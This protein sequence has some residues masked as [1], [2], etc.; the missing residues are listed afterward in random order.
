M[1]RGF[2]Y[3][4]RR[5]AGMRAALGLA[6]SV[7]YLADWSSEGTFTRASEA[8]VVDPR[9]GWGFVSTDPAT[10]MGAAVATAENEGSGQAFSGTTTITTGVADPFGG[11]DA[12]T[13]ADD[14]GSGFETANTPQSMSADVSDAMV[15]AFA[16]KADA[17]AGAWHRLILRQGTSARTTFE[18]DPRTGDWRVNGGSVTPARVAFYSSDG[19][20]YVI[21]SYTAGQ[22]TTS[23]TWNV[24]IFGAAG[25][26][27]WSLDTSATG[28]ITLSPFF[29]GAPSTTVE[30]GYA[31]DDVRRVLSDGAILLE[32][33]RTNVEAESQSLTD[34][35][36]QSGTGGTATVTD[37]DG[38]APDGTS[39]GT[40]TGAG[41]T[42]NEVRRFG[43]IV[44]TNNP[45]TASVYAE[46]VSG[47]ASLEC[48][49]SSVDHSG[50]AGFERL[51]VTRA[52]TNNKRVELF[53]IAGGSGGTLVAGQEARFWGMQ[54]EDA[55]FPT[56]PIRT[57][58]A[59]AT[60]AADAFSLSSSEAADF[61]DALKA[62]T[63]VA[64]DVWPEFSS[65]DTREN[66]PRIFTF[67]LNVFG[68]YLSGTA[69]GPAV[70]ITSSGTIC[71]VAAVAWDRYDK[72]RFTLTCPE[73][74]TWNLK[75]EN[76]TQG[77]EADDDS[78]G[79]TSHPGTFDSQTLH[80]G[81]YA[82][83]SFRFTGV[84]GRPYEA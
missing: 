3:L 55:D 80:V 67:G 45:G 34:F 69:G 57:D 23:S 30:P 8:S 1:P 19:W 82:T 43:P 61:R 74:G 28:E 62:G 58:G 72:L 22:L 2:P 6:N 29:F 32:E 42:L 75:M 41:A 17:S 47:A 70:L 37:P 25:S 33:A 27:Q 35:V 54:L 52:N 31:H 5:A 12:V 51:D 40:L 48:N 66:N 49:G 4:R 26:T 21:A 83:G 64:I 59:T 7:V 68:L 44:S 50:G 60:R 46:V 76:V 36:A 53:T 65:T 77:T 13:L 24:Q 71:S 11:T 20:Y 9:S 14:D 84:I 38:D 63:P 78:A 18:V 10:S 73:G 15:F 39:A 79:A 56:S 16:F 81:N